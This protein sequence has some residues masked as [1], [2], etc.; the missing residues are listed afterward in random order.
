MKFIPILFSTPM[1]QAILEGRKTMT[2]RII[3]PQPTEFVDDPLYW[4][5]PVPCIKGKY[6]LS[7]SIKCPYGQPGDVF[8]VRENWSP[9]IGSQGQQTIIYAADCKEVNWAH[10][11]DYYSLGWHKRPSIHMPKI[12]CRLFHKV[13][14]IKVERLQDISEQDAIAEGVQLH[15]RG[16][17]NFI[18]RP[19]DVLR[20]YR[21]C[22]S[23][24]WASINGPESWKANPWVWVIEFERIEKPKKFK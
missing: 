10:D 2:R 3:T 17:V 7:Q 8:W 15:F 12:A 11:K 13:K 6:D 18:N 5:N 21:D 1:V 19:S 16:I 24:L 9:C 14:S 22:F 23:D 20:P 4:I